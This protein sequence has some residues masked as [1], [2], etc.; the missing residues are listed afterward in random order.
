MYAIYNIMF[1]VT[2]IWIKPFF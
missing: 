2:E 1:L